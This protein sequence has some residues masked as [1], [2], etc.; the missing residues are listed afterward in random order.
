MNVLACPL[1]TYSTRSSFSFVTFCFRV[2]NETGGYVPVFFHVKLYAQKSVVGLFPCAA[3]RSANHHAD[4]LSE[5]RED[6]VR[7]SVFF[8]M[9]ELSVVYFQD[10]KTP[11]T[12]C[13]NLK[14]P[15]EKNNFVRSSRRP[16][17]HNSIDSLQ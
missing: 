14:P 8:S 12:L 16:L 13:Q 6:V 15:N 9:R 17:C 7:T 11:P 3:T 5:L 10:P 2:I 4:A 1:R